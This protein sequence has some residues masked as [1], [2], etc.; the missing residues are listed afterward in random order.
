MTQSVIAQVAG[1]K[2]LGTPELRKKWRELYENDPPPFNRQYLEA[3]IAYRLQELVHGGLTKD[4]HK[5]I[6]SLR[7]NP[8]EEKILQKIDPHKPPI[9]AILV[10]E[11]RGV[12]HRVRVVQDGFEYS[13]QTYRSLTAI[14]TKIAG[15]KWNGPMFFGLRRKK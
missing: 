12:E 3:R 1:L 4:S 2:A 10:R 6:K 11:H 5:R 14:A 9:G 15:V 8:S 13:G 7:P